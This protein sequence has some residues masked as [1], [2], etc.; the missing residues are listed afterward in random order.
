M[1][2]SIV[3]SMA[4]ERKMNLSIPT[5]PV[6]HVG[7]ALAVAYLLRLN[8]AVTLLCAIL[9]DLVDKPLTALLWISEGRYIAHTLL[10]VFL[11]SIA[12]FLW[13]RA[14]GLAALVG[15]ISHLLLDSGSSPSWFWL[16]AS[17]RL[18]F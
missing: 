15:G 6:G 13:K 5:G 2:C 18:F 7:I 11:V 1:N 9:P 8:L 12:F 3:I 14:Y 16:A 10:F 4:T 17:Y